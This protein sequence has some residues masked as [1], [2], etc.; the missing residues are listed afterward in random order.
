MLTWNGLQ[1]LYVSFHTDA[2]VKIRIKASCSNVVTVAVQ[3][4]IL[5]VK[6]KH[7]STLRFKMFGIWKWWFVWD[8]AMMVCFPYEQNYYICLVHELGHYGMFGDLVSH[9]RLCIFPFRLLGLKLWNLLWQNA[10]SNM[11]WIMSILH[12]SSKRFYGFCWWS[13]NLL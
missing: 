13:K 6:L 5:N 12:I 2:L 3:C 9:S 7:I 4:T 11:N 8:M 10:F 1:P